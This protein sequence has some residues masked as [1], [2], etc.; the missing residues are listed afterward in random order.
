MCDAFAPDARRE[1]CA[2]ALTQ[3]DVGNTNYEWRMKMNLIP[4][5]G[6]CP[7]YIIFT[8]RIDAKNLGS[9]AI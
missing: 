3:F 2:P 4:L 8:R 6:S 1:D 5:F 7:I 9:K